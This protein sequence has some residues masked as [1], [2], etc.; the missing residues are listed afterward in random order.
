M[1]KPRLL[2][3]SSFLYAL[4]APRDKNHLLA[5]EFALKD[6]YIPL[7]AEVALTEVCY[8]L[9]IRGGLAPMTEFL[10]AFASNQL[11]PL[12]LRMQDYGRIIA[13]A[14]HY[15]DAKFD[16]VDCAIMA[17]SERLDVAEV[18]TFDR[19]DFNIYRRPD[20]RPLR[21]LP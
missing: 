8:L 13:I 18:A 10:R 20:K 14:E 15:R 3:D 16:F 4:Y 11:I 19:R 5:R 1:D 17:L 21:L 9:F 6:S 2:I 7:V 12:S